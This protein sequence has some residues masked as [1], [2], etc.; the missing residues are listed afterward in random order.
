MLKTATFILLVCAGELAA[1]RADTI[2]KTAGRPVHSGVATLRRELSIGVADGDEKYMLGAIADVAVSASGDIYVWDRSIPA[3]RM[4]D[5]SGKYIRTIGRLGSVPGEYRPG[6]AL[7][8]GRN[9][10]LLM[11]DPGTARINVYTASGDIVTSWPT[12]SGSS[13]SIEGRGL[14]TVDVNGVTHAQS[15]FF[16]NQPG[17]PADTRTGW[18]RYRPA[19]SLQDTVFKPA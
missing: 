6:G 11:W 12:K 17:K 14:L 10:N 15:M 7:A 1:Q 9:G 13:G 16:I 19:G 3:I 2:V 18:I 4:Y 8:V 5:A